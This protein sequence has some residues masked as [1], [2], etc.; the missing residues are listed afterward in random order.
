M[1][2]ARCWCILGLTITAAACRDSGTEPATTGPVAAAQSVVTVSSATV[3]SG[4]TVGLTLTTKDAQGR[5]LTRGGLTVVFRASGGLSTGTVSATVDRGNGTYTASFRGIEAGLA[6]TIE[7]SINGEPVT[8]PLPTV[9]VRPGPFSPAT[10]IVTVKPRT[11]V[12]GGTATIELIARDA[13]E[14]AHDAG[15]L[16]VSLTIGGGSAAGTLGPVTDHANG[17]YSATFTAAAVGTPLTIGTTVNGTPVTTPPPTVSVARG[18]STELSVVEVSSDSISVDASLR[19]TFEARDSAGVRR[20]SGGDTVRFLIQRD[21]SGG[22]GTVGSVTDHDDGS[23]SANV[24]GTRDGLVRIGASINKRHHF[25]DS[26]C[27]AKVHSQRERRYDRGGKNGD[28]LRTAPR[29]QR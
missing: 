23:Y 13:A 19:V 25:A 18:I 15:G 3:A 20:T 29:S 16:R 7:A 24:T 26:R 8:S 28:V 27:T 6:T 22:D 11:I 12:A 1:R 5:A 17:R 10:S 14:N 4:D 9:R 21:A 2:A